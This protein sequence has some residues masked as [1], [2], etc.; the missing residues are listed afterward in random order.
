MTL[1]LVFVLGCVAMAAVALR[2]VFPGTGWFS[3][4]TRSARYLMAAASL[5][6]AAQ[7]L[8]VAVA[9]RMGWDVDSS[10]AYTLQL[11]V[12]I[13]TLMAAS[14]VVMALHRRRT[15][16]TNASESSGENTPPGTPER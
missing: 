8:V 2:M 3:A 9:A 5:H 10:P 7:P 11:F 15:G 1:S 12:P 14:N 4:F 16:S 6:L 13:I